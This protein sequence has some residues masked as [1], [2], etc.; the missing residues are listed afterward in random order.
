MAV[1]RLNGKQF[2]WPKAQG[3]PVTLTK[4]QF[5][6]LFAGLDWRQLPAAAT[7]KPVFV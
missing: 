1:K 6:A 7:R 3:V 4:V 2:V 5:E